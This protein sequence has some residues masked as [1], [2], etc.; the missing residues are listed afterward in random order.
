M[1]PSPIPLGLP[2][3]ISVR[4]DGG[5]FE[6]SRTW[7]GWSTVAQSVFTLFWC[8]FLVF[9]YSMALSTEAPLVMILFPLVHVAV[10]IGLLYSSLAGWLNRTRIRIGEGV[11]QIR[12]EPLPWPGSKDV[13]VTDL[14]QLYVVERVSRSR[15]GTTVRYQVQAITNSGKTIKIVSGLADSD[16]AHYIEQE[17]ERYTGIRDVPVK[18]EMGR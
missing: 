9:W 15:N 13:Q 8:G 6:I 3:K 7:F 17:V 16:Q 1:E 2:D 14:K 5:A 4:N 12:H 10:G 11:L 18:G